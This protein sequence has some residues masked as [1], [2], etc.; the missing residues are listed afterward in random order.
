MEWLRI[1][2]E[3]IRERGMK[4]IL[5]G[6]V[7]PART[8]SKMSWDETCWQKYAL[9][10]HQFRDVVIGSI[11]GHMNLDHFML[12]DSKDIDIESFLTGEDETGN[13]RSYLDSGFSLTSAEDYLTDL[14]EDWSNLPEPPWSPSAWPLATLNDSPLS[15]NERYWDIFANFF[16]SKKSKNDESKWGKHEEEKF[17]KKIG[18]KWAERFSMSLVSPSVVPN[19]YPTLRV[20]SYNISGIEDPPVVPDM[21]SIPQTTLEGPWIDQEV[22]LDFGEEK[23]NKKKKNKKHPKKPSITIPKPPP[24]SAPPG[25]A[26]SSQTLSWLGYVQYYAN[27]T[28]INNDLQGLPIP[29]TS[30][31]V[32]ALS[33][34]STNITR[35]HPG[36]HSGK[37]PHK[38]NPTPDTKKFVYEVEY[39]TFNDSIFTLPD[40]TI[41]NF[42]ELAR[43]IGQYHPD[44][45]DQMP[46][47]LGS[48]CPETLE[49]DS[50]MNMTKKRKKHKNRHAKN[51]AWF[52]FV[53][54]AFVGTIDDEDLHQRYGQEIIEDG[55]E[56]LHLS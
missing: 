48:S 53:K 19:Y 54:R 42:L 1:Q 43:R 33:E 16:R 55:E 13:L 56:C 5:M 50:R 41:R 17:F 52:T 25:P 28:T 4:A 38:R 51:K 9:W 32:E 45:A 49:E 10:M 36:K 23:K 37:E 7:P 20:I 21:S 27:L 6:H 26:Y 18:G 11:Y 30:L 12:Q 35:W 8:S 3:F 24:K 31:A 39:S 2:L 44:K 29:N 34:R 22:D 47:P 15:Q 14:R 40:L 46:S